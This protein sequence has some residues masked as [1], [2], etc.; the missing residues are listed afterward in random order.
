MKKEGCFFLGIITKKHG[1]KGDVNIKL[2]VTPSK[3]FR[4]LNHLFIELN[5]SLVPFFISSWRYKNNNIALIKFEDISDEES[6]NTLIGKS[7]YLPLEYL[8]EDE[9]PLKA[10]IH[11]NVVDKKHGQI[12][13]ISDIQS[14]NGQD[15]FIINHNGKEIL[16]PV[17]QEF[18]SSIDKTTKT[19]NLIT[20]EGLIDLFL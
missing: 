13:E 20:P 18:I 9:S 5:G 10:L 2:D 11:Y 8:P 7:T 3:S 12:G 15:L 6:A 16:I 17:T 14:N 19:I 1:Y 4:E